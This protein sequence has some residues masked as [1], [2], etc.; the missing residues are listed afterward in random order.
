MDSLCSARIP[1][2]DYLSLQ[3]LH[4]DFCESV[5]V[6]LCVCALSWCGGVTPLVRGCVFVSCWAG[7]KTV[8]CCMWCVYIQ[9]ASLF[10]FPIKIFKNPRKF[11]SFTDQGNKKKKNIRAKYKRLDAIFGKYRSSNL[12]FFLLCSSKWTSYLFH[13]HT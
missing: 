7:G 12:F 3:L 9:R 5:C 6:C 4:R 11:Y 8:L 1:A 10:F 2:M 13:L